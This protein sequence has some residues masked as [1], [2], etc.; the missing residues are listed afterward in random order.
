MLCEEC[1]ERDATVMVTTVINGETKTR[2][3]CRECVKKYQKGGD[4]SALLAAILSSMYTAKESGG[5]ACPRCG[6]TLAEFN[7]G[8]M[9]GCSECYSAF[10][11]ELDP[12]LNRIQGR[13]QHAGR[14][15]YLDPDAREK[16]EKVTRIRRA[17][18]AAVSE[19]AFEEAARLRD[20]LKALTASV[21]T[22]EKEEEPD[23]R[24]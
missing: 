11:E 2:N 6:M 7:S 3:L 18:E 23:G 1:G 15:P 22:V 14:K 5:K 17:M 8:G 20:E 10:R 16:A 12:M 9:F 19:E 24:E 13:V 4:I 21:G